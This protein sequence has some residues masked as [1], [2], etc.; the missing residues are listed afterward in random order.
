MQKDFNFQLSKKGQAK[1]NAVFLKYADAEI[2][3]PK[4]FSISQ[5]FFLSLPR[6]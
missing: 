6:Q 5:K 4:N 2:K 3:S 1:Y